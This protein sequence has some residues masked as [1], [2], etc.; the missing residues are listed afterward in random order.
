MLIESSNE[1]KGKERQEEKTNPESVTNHVVTGTPLIVPVSKNE[2][3]VVAK[4]EP[5][6]SKYTIIDNNLYF[7]LYH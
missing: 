1:T 5:I 4:P 3:E 6:D 2:S 7:V